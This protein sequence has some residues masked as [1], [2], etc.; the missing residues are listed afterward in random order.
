[1]MRDTGIP[2]FN[3]SSRLIPLVTLFK[4]SAVTCG[5]GGGGGGG[6]GRT[7][8]NVSGMA[9]GFATL[10]RCPE[11]G[12]GGGTDSGAPA[13]ALGPFT[14]AGPTSSRGALFELSSGGFAAFPAAL[15]T[16]P[17]IAVIPSLTFFPAA[18]PIA[19]PAAEA[20]TSV[21]VCADA[22]PAA[23]K[24]KIPRIQYLIWQRNTACQT[25]LQAKHLTMPLK[26]N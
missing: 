5:A 20:P 22:N 8:G 24:K 16:L 11:A 6:G 25:V 15:S 14:V 13:L 2:S 21:I 17:K 10:A 9:A 12:G 3:T 1:M 18:L 23:S 19:P 26:N 4:S 7:S